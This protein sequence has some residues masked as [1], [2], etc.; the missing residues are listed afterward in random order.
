VVSGFYHS[1]PDHP[2]LPS[3]FDTEHAWP[4]YTYVVVS[5]D[6]HGVRGVG[7]FE[8]DA[9]RQRFLPCELAVDALRAVEPGAVGR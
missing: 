5:V 9:E 8:L 4:W 2:A 1:H 7:A 6:A 3:A